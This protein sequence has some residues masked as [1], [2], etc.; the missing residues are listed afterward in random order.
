MW[1]FA[2]FSFSI[3]TKWNRYLS[4]SFIHF[5]VVYNIVKGMMPCT[6]SELLVGNLGRRRIKANALTQLGGVAQNIQP[7]ELELLC[8]L[9]HVTGKAL[10]D[11][12]HKTKTYLKN[13]PLQYHSYTQ[14]PAD[15]IVFPLSMKHCLKRKMR[16]SW[17]CSSAVEYLLKYPNLI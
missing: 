9:C 16:N 3:A 7:R 15:S 14:S 1:T 10:S 4:E 11:T 2:C 8:L 13:C 17:G 12:K 5:A 6:H